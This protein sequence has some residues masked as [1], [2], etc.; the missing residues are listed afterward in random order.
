ML[1]SSSNMQQIL[2]APFKIIAGRHSK[3]ETGKNGLLW[4][5][6]GPFQGSETP[7][8]HQ[9]PAHPFTRSLSR[10][11]GLMSVGGRLLQSE[12]QPDASH[13]IVL[14]HKH[15][16]S[17][18][19]IQ[20]LDES[21]KRPGPEGVFTGGI[22]AIQNYQHNCVDRQRWPASLSPVRLRGRSL[23]G[24]TRARISSEEWGHLEA[25]LPLLHPSSST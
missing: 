17:K 9:S 16:V 4:R 14:D 15:P 20:G 22:E 11:T 19:L 1:Q 24:Q 2:K 10:P 13:L 25:L 3:S 18:L 12:Q 8:V 6:S 23:C 5:R 21:L 7:I